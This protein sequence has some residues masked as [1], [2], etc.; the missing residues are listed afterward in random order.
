MLSTS[1]LTPSAASAA[2]LYEHQGDSAAAMDAYRSLTGSEAP[3]SHAYNQSLLAYLSTGDEVFIN[4]MDGWKD[5]WDVRAKNESLSSRKKTRNDFILTFNECLVIFVSGKPREASSAVLKHLIPMVTEN[6]IVHE[7]LLNITTQMAFLVLDCIL[8]ISQGHH[9]GLTQVDDVCTSE[10]LVNWLEKQ[11]L[12]S[13]AQLKFLLQIYKSRINFAQRDPTQGKIVDAKIRGVKK[14]LKQAMEL[15][16]HKIRTTGETSSVGSY[17]DRG[18]DSVANV[19]REKFNQPAVDVGTQEGL[20]QAHLQSALNLKAHLEQLKGNTNKSLLLCAEATASHNDP[21][22]ESISANNLAFIY[23]TSRKRH[24]ALH[25]AAKALRAPS[26]GTFRSDGTARCNST[27]AI[28]ANAALCALQ[29]RRYEAAYECMATCVLNSTTYGERPRCWLRMAEAC[30]GT[31]HE[32]VDGHRRSYDFL[33]TLIWKGLHVEKRKIRLSAQ[34]DCGFA[35]VKQ[36]GKAKAIVAQRADDDASGKRGGSNATLASKEDLEYFSKYPLQQASF[37]LDRVMKLLRDASIGSPGLKMDRDCLES[38]RCAQAYVMLELKEYKQ[39]LFLAKLLLMDAA[40]MKDTSGLHNVMH[41][42][43]KATASMYGC[44]ACCALGDSVG[45]LKFLTGEKEDDSVL[46]RLAADLAGVGTDA[47]ADVPTE[48]N[49][50][51]SRRKMRLKLAQ[52][53][54]RTSASAATA[55]MGR[56]GTAKK[57][58]MSAI[59]LEDVAGLPPS[60]TSRSSARK[61]LLYCMLREG[62]RDGALAVLRS[63][64]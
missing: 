40:T 33:L 63:S 54:V 41:K 15:F 16:N 10:A 18:D 26:G 23:A 58:A 21:S 19:T 61:A 62:N 49:G 53:M 57:L 35:V 3:F 55:A 28:L 46:D 60:D 4:E 14:E 8:A 20:L 12:D 34:S 6:E 24:L 43:R 50:T 31:F 22:Y 56:L 2:S 13:D 7:E 29:G 42:R 25:T 27:W 9:G 64:R 11:D 39:A 47:Q 59:S 52:A 44:E 45:A 36:D 51:E 32:F 48:D 1:N 30:I 5:K 17:S 37:C 38:A